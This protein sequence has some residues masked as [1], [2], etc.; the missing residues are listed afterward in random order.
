[1]AMKLNPGQGIT[2]WALEE[3]LVSLRRYV[4]MA[5]GDRLEA[6]QA[7]IVEIEDTLDEPV[8]PKTVTLKATP[9]E[10]DEWQRAA[11]ESGLSRMAWCVAMLNIASG[12]STLAE[13]AK[14]VAN[15]QAKQAAQAST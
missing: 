8:E 5:E 14:R 10:I 6:L 11:G 9:A 7:E 2:R 15:A 4:I 3:R 13:H 1:M 12:R